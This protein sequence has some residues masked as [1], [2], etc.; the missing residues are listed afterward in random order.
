MA[1]ASQGDAPGALA[2]V[3]AR[4]AHI[5]RI[6]LGGFQRD[7]TRGMNADERTEEQAI[8]RELIST[9]AQTITERSARKPDPAR[10]ERLEQQ[11][12]TL[13]TK[14]AEQQSRLYARLPELEQWRGLAP[15]PSTQAGVAATSSVSTAPTA[16]TAPVSPKPAGEGGRLLLVEYVVSD[17]EILI[18][19]VSPKPEGESGP[20]AT[21]TVVPARQR[22]LAER[23]EQAMQAAVLR[24]IVEWRKKAMPLATA[25]I[26]PIAARLRDRDRIV[27][28]PDD[29]LWKVPFEALPV[30]EGDLS[31]RARVTYATSL[32]A[33]AAQRQAAERTPP[34]D[35]LVAG[36]AGAPDIPAAIRAQVALT[37]Q[38]WKEPDQAVSLAMT[39]E[40]AK[41]YGG[42]ATVK[43]AADATEAA[44]RALLETSDVVH[45]GAPLQMSGPTP[46]FSS[47]LLAGVADTPGNDGRWEA[48]GWFNIDGRAIS[49]GVRRE[50]RSNGCPYNAAGP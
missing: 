33:L 40:I 19:S 36:I 42:V 50:S 12:A 10:L 32:A 25:L 38:S 27:I 13:V 43:T 29:L 30:G 45:V 22:D 20:D 34:P 5:R 17:E 49:T 41:T 26:E 9:R 35:H 2:A 3:E 6:Q 18:V 46:L 47:L 28:V 39:S 31:S 23:I 7:I 1:L 15:V 24:D 14:R 37:S 44:V 11:L 4:R 48:R 21:A 16:P 8:V